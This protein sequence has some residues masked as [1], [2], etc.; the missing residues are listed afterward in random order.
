MGITAWIAVCMAA[1]SLVT[2]VLPG[3]RCPPP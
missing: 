2:I 1:G 3:K